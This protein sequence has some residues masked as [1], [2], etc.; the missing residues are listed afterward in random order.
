MASSRYPLKKLLTEAYRIYKQMEDSRVLVMTRSSKLP[1]LKKLLELPES[2][3]PLELIH[4]KNQHHKESGKLKNLIDLLAY[5]SEAILDIKSPAAA[6]KAI[7]RIKIDDDT[8]YIQIL[9]VL[10]KKKDTTFDDSFAEL[11]KQII[12]L[13]DEI[14]IITTDLKSPISI[15]HQEL[16]KEILQLKKQ[17]N[18]SQVTLKV[19]QSQNTALTKSLTKKE[20]E[21]SEQI[22]LAEHM[23]TAYRSAQIALE[24]EVKKSSDHESKS[25]AAQKLLLE[26]HE[27]KKAQAK[28]LTEQTATI[29]GL[30]NKIQELDKHYLYSPA[31]DSVITDSDVKDLINLIRADMTLETRYE[32]ATTMLSVADNKND[33]EAVAM[34]SL[35]KEINHFYERFSHVYRSVIFENTSDAASDEKSTTTELEE[36]KKLIFEQLASRAMGQIMECNNLRMFNSGINASSQGQEKFSEKETDAVNKFKEKILQLE[37]KQKIIAAFYEEILKRIENTEKNKIAPLAKRLGS[38]AKRN[39]G[40]LINDAMQSQTKELQLIA[41]MQRKP[42]PM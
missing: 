11:S 14:K 25:N 2:Q 26:F 40:K 28:Q 13:I 27:D 7:E 17:I 9:S 36:S 37:A 16:Q 38:F 18:E 31:T 4:L 29:Q 20:S 32:A 12:N 19:L 1:E 30:N 42:A 5:Y 35:K 41:T 23:K 15:S 34:R 33:S 6:K 21:L 10:K 8:A 24:Q 39:Y 22:H 3:I